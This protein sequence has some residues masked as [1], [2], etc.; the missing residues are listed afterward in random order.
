MPSMANGTTPSARRSRHDESINFFRGGRL[1]K[2]LSNADAILLVGVIDGAVAGYAYGRL[3][4]RDWNALLDAHGGFHDLWVEDRARR[5]GLGRGLA[6]AMIEAMNA[7]GVPRVVLKTSTKNAAAQA[8][9]T[10]LGWRPTML[11][12]TRER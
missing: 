1:G 11:E 8:L 12:M 3:E 7:R 2:E 9:F 6:T 10:S 4:E 5:S